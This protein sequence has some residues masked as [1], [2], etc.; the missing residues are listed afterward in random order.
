MRNIVLNVFGYTEPS[1][2][3]IHA[4]EDLTLPDF[5]SRPLEAQDCGLRLGGAP[6]KSS[7]QNDLSPGAGTGAIVDPIYTE[8][9]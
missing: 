4:T 8:V 2:Q 1:W 9:E 3:E 7:R 5:R 6:L